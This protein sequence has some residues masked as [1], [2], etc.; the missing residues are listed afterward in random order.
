MKSAIITLVLTIALFATIT[1]NA[2]T[3]DGLASKEKCSNAP[4]QAM[5]ELEQPFN[6]W[7]QIVC[8]DIDKAHYIV[9]DEEHIWTDPSGK[10]NFQFHAYG[11]KPPK[12]KLGSIELNT[13]EP[14]K[15]HYLKMAGGKMEGDKASNVNKMLQMSTGDNSINYDDI[16]QL[17]VISNTRNIYN[18]FVYLK[19]D[20]PEWMIGCSNKCNQSVHLKVEEQ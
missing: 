19:N 16:Y 17:D 15:Y 20:K 3:V 11:I 13:F 12:L 5:T 18:I 14:H 8:S 9:P 6:E 7:F 4:E 1:A 10:K 2:I